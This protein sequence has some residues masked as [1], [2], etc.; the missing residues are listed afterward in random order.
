MKKS[1]YS[2]YSIKM[3]TNNIRYSSHINFNCF[4]F[5]FV[6]C[7]LD[8][9]LVNSLINLWNTTIHLL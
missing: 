5:S 8:M 2:K 3:K 9:L 6:I 1:K 7:P 4:N